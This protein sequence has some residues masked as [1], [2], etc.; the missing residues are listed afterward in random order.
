MDWLIQQG[1][2]WDGGFIKLPKNTL[3][4]WWAGNNITVY[5]DTCAGTWDESGRWTISCDL[6]A[7]VVFDGCVQGV[8]RMWVYEATS[9]IVW[10]DPA[11]EWTGYID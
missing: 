11:I 1:G 4:I 3:G 10:A 6:S 5:P 9:T 8:V 2:Q 7:C